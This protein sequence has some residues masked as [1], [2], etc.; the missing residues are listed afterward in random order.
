MRHERPKATADHAVP[1]F[2]VLLVELCSYLLRNVGVHIAFDDGGLESVLSLLNGQLLH[3]VIHVFGKN[4]GLEKS[5][6]TIGC[7]TRKT[8]P[9]LNP[10]NARSVLTIILIAFFIIIEWINREL[11]HDF[12]IS[13]YKTYIR[14]PF[15]LFIFMLILFFGKS[16][17]TFI[18]FH[19]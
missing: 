9:T 4:N 17:D 6:E 12:E 11:K 16:S 5:H 19:F 2:G 15:Y 13:K 1:P 18:Y 7:D 8:T 3:L 10:R 14:W